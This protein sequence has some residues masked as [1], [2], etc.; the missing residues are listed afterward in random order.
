MKQ[1][2]KCQ[3]IEF[4]NVKRLEERLQI[5]FRNNKYQINSTG[6]SLMG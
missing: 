6:W 1:F 2:H 3:K 4:N 5:E